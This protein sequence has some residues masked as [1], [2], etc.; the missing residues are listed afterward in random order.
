MASS[1]SKAIP[2][3]DVTPPGE[4]TLDFDDTS[5][6]EDAAN[7]SCRS[8]TSARTGYKLFPVFG[9]VCC[10]FYLHVCLF[11]CFYNV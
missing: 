10:C 11:D 8:S 1:E 7:A 9:F 3:S 6:G 5:K 2:E 4:E